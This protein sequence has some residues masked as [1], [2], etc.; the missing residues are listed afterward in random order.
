MSVS[1]SITSLAT[2]LIAQEGLLGL[3][4]VVFGPGGVLHSMLEE[5]EESVDPR[6]FNITIRHLLQHTAGF[7]TLLD[8]NDPTSDPLFSSR[9]I[10]SELGIPGPASCIDTMHFMLDLPLA[11]TP[12]T[13]G[14]YS[15]FGYCVLGRVIE[16]ATNT[17]YYSAVKNW[18]LEPAGVDL[19]EMYL[20]RVRREEIP[21]EEAEYKPQAPLDFLAP[22]VYPMDNDKIV[23]LAYGGAFCAEAADAIGGWVASS[24]QLLKIVAAVAPPHCQD[25]CL[26]DE[27]WLQELVAPPSYPWQMDW[28]VG[29]GAFFTGRNPVDD[30][31]T[32]YRSLT[33]LFRGDNAGSLALVV[34]MNEENGYAYA[35]VFNG[36]NS[37]GLIDDATF[38]TPLDDMAKC[39]NGNEWPF[40]HFSSM[41]DADEPSASSTAKILQTGALIFALVMYA[42]T[43]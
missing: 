12:G 21:P 10:T 17:T 4:N 25:D 8:E 31:M 1:K 9:K 32:D 2:L 27:S 28:Y 18:L 3:D 20:G 14:D 22:S 43:N 23:S 42:S 34:R 38:H 36:N 35:A 33:W 15:N 24:R 29:L 39:V 40:D 7:A 6:I 13:K 19:N 41:T 37:T 5:H 26:L 30:T 11:Y 16:G